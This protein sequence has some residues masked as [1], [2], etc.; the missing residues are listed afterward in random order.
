GGHSLLATQALARVREAFD[1]DLS[2][3]DFFEAPTAAALAARVETARRAGRPRIERAR[4]DRPL[5]AS[6]TQ[7]RF[8]W[9]EQLQPDTALHNVSLQVNVPGR[10]APAIVA[11]AI[12]SIVRRHEVLR[13]T[14]IPID[15]VPM[16]RIGPAG[17]IDLQAWDLR[18]A[19]QAWSLA[20]ERAGRPFDL[21]HGPLLRA[22]FIRVSVDLALVQVTMHHIV[23]DG[24]SQG[25]FLRELWATI[26]A[27]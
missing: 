23:T 13:T 8:W 20:T 5:P 17:S 9:R 22:S 25:I 4:R 15:G 6:S 27:R 3:T 2:L 24:W 11:A 21:E 16:Q 18:T 19:P 14:F 26:D 10:V 12:E 1:V 7:Q